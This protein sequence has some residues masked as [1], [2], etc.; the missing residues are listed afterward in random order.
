MDN[1]FLARLLLGMAALAA[2]PLTGSSDPALVNVTAII[3]RVY[4]PLFYS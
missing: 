3:E 4:V 1:R 2:V